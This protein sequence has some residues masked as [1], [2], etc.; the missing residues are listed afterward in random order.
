MQPQC[1]KVLLKKFCFV[2]F[3][4]FD[5]WI[6][7]W[8][9]VWIWMDLQYDLMATDLLIFSVFQLQPVVSHTQQRDD[10]VNQSEDAV[11][12]QKAVP[13]RSADRYVT[14]SLTGCFIRSDVMPASLDLL[15]TNIRQCGSPKVF[16][17]VSCKNNKT[18]QRAR[19]FD[20]CKRLKGNP[21]SLVWERAR[22]EAMPLIRENVFH[23]VKWNIS[24]LK[25]KHAE[26]HCFNLGTLCLLSPWQPTYGCWLIYLIM[27]THWSI[28]WQPAVIETA[29][30]LIDFVLLWKG[31]L[32]TSCKI[33]TQLPKG[34]SAAISQPV[35]W[36][37]PP[38]APTC[39][40]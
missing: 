38:L 40:C 35:L 32:N 12:P 8:K 23:P 39:V 31:F 33:S 30:L 14:D 27:V 1:H 4:A 29:L 24:Q 11:Q 26:L 3:L 37:A 10:E 25:F 6:N 5:F 22:N 2:F 20:F 18:W 16:R 7:I 13:L 34:I 19:R 36:T 9:V 21:S 17:T 15:C 28:W